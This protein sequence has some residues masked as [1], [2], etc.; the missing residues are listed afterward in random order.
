MKKSKSA[1]G[2]RKGNNNKELLATF[3]KEIEEEQNA[4]KKKRYLILG[5]LFAGVLVAG[6]ISGNMERSPATVTTPEQ[7]VTEEV[8]GDAFSKKQTPED[9]DAELAQLQEQNLIGEDFKAP[10]ALT[11]DKEDTS[12]QTEKPDTVQAPVKKVE[13]VEKEETP[14]Q[15]ALVN[16]PD[17]SPSAAIAENRVEA[18]VADTKRPETEDTKK[19][20][21]R[22]YSVQAMAT[23]DSARALKRRDDLLRRGFDAWIYMGKVKRSL[24][25]V[26]V[27][28]FGAIKD[29]SMLSKLLFDVGYSNKVAYI[30]NGARITLD[31]G[32]FQDRRGAEKLTEKIVADG[33]PA[34]VKSAHAPTELYL[35][36]IGRFGSIP[37]AEKENKRLQESGY[38]SL[39][40]IGGLNR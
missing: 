23:T 6:F 39:G 16:P 25:K 2:D 12:S 15:T 32:T 38:D 37:E 14:V 22:R 34:K 24:Y 27:G 17:E 4:G 26:E 11:R 1:A 3:E 21:N 18:P 10:G 36:R 28:N 31:M 20:T 13:P 5:G 7:V 9:V 19:T 40:V 8:T 33:F 35:V 29:A 30:N